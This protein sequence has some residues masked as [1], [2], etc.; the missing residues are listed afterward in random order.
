MR[1]CV[2]AASSDKLKDVFYETAF[3]FGKKMAQRGHSLVYGGGATGLMGACAKGVKSL[4]GKVIGISPGFFDLP[5]VLLSEADEMIFTETM[6]ERKSRMRELSDAFVTL[7]GG[8]GSFEEFFETLTLKQLGTVESAIAVLNAEGCY[9][10]L[11]EMI[12]KSVAEGF[13]PAE[14]LD[15]FAVFDD[16]EKLL[17][18]V[19]EYRPER[20]ELWREKMIRRKYLK[21]E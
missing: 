21:E 4:G 2:Y 18:F 6:A 19:E 11:V 12:D 10:K 1:I 16:M 15:M 17:N 8:I 9:D 7:P 14:T 20:K 3:E 5:G 13:T